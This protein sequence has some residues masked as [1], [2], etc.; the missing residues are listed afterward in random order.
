MEYKVDISPKMREASR[1]LQEMCIGMDFCIYEMGR[2]L[3][4]ETPKRECEHAVKTLKEKFQDVVLITKAYG[5][6]EDL[7]DFILVKQMISESPVFE[8]E[9]IPVP[10]LEKQ[11]VDLSTD[12]MFNHKDIKE[13]G[14][15]FQHA[16]ET[17]NVNKSRM[18]R[19][20]A[21]KGKKEEIIGIIDG[22]DTARI[23]T[24]KAIQHYLSET[25]FEKVWMFGSFSRM[26]DGPDSDIDLL[27]ELGKNNKMGLIELSGIVMGLEKVSQRTIDLVIEGS[28][29]PFALD[30]IE[31]DK[32][33]IYERAR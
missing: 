9:E 19:Y 10:V 8:M 16:F 3:V 14:L 30:S 27:A 1:W 25:P 20:A 29:K 15:A 7:H 17:Y 24:V 28:V 31:K 6:L 2:N 21:R 11:L 18:V 33:L 5:M 23:K 26:E 12:K 4:V 22:L 32:V 13:R